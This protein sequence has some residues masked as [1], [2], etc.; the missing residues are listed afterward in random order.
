V[1]TITTLTIKHAEEINEKDKEIVRLKEEIAKAHSQKSLDDKINRDLNEWNCE[2]RDEMDEMR[3]IKPVSKMLDD[4]DETRVGTI[5]EIFFA[6]RGWNARFK[7]DI[8]AEM[9]LTKRAEM[10]VV[11]V[12]SDVNG[13]SKAYIKGGTLMFATKINPTKVSVIECSLVGDMDYLNERYGLYVKST[14]AFGTRFKNDTEKNKQDSKLPIL[15]SLDEN[16]RYTGNFKEE[17]ED[18]FRSVNGWTLNHENI[19]AIADK[20]GSFQTREQNALFLKLYTEKP[21]DCFASRELIK[22]SSKKMRTFA[23]WK[24]LYGYWCKY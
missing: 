3:G 9:K 11:K 5:R 16:A 19:E 17:A 8:N 22:L 7:D 23:A 1:K 18:T 6:I 20:V 12:V 2:T 4:W 21:F 13:S 10:S 15:T 14:Y 24:L